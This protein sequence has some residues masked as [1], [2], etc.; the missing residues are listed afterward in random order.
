MRAWMN[1]FQEREFVW[2]NG[3]TKPRRIFRPQIFTLTCAWS[4]RQERWQNR[5]LHHMP[6]YPLPTAKFFAA[7]SALVATDA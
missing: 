1:I 6:L 5:P 7:P 3:Q 2:S 4:L